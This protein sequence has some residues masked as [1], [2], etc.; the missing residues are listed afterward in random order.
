[1]KIHVVDDNVLDEVFFSR[2]NS[3]GKP[4]S[5]LELH[6]TKHVD[7]KYYADKMLGVDTEDQLMPMMSMDEYDALADKLSSAKAS[8]VRDND[9]DIIGYVTKNGNR[10]KYQ[11]STG[12]LV[13]YVDDDEKGHEAI[14]L[15]KQP[16]GKFKHRLEGSPKFKYASDLPEEESISNSKDENAGVSADNEEQNTAE[17]TF[18]D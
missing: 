1:M 8:N 13:A 15:Y 7:P 14:A 9:A 12:Y 3:N 10:V 6:Y 4:L 16:F 5:N 2:R 11:K 18:E 17:E